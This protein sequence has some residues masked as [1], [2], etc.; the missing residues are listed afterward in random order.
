MLGG[1]GSGVKPRQR[2]PSDPCSENEKETRG[3]LRPSGAMD[4][5]VLEDLPRLERGLELSWLLRHKRK[6]AVMHISFLK[7]LILLSRGGQG[8]GKDQ[9]SKLALRALQEID[10]PG[11]QDLEP[12]SL[13]QFLMCFLHLAFNAPADSLEEVLGLARRHLQG[14][15]DRLEDKA[16]AF[17]LLRWAL[18]RW[19]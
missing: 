5:P 7:G 11:D 13:E 19:P 8:L 4:Q 15:E 12:G 17:Q 6:Y 14:V 9:V 16:Y 3:W 2:R 1:T 10:W 18:H